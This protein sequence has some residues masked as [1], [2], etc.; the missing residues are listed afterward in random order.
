[1]SHCAREALGSNW[2]LWSPVLVSE[3][4]QRPL[5]PSIAPL[6]P[7]GGSRTPAM[8]GLPVGRSLLRSAQAC[9]PADRKGALQC[10]RP[11]AEGE[12]YSLLHT[13]VFKNTNWLCLH[14]LKKTDNLAT[15]FLLGWT[16]SSPAALLCPPP[17]P[18]P[19]GGMCT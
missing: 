14:F 17:H 2:P 11:G 9:W 16:A 10:G 4:R 3:E 1:M 19:S 6:Q 15:P 12:V 7:Q 5:P 13:Q 8:A 18:R